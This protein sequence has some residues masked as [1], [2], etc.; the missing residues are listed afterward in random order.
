MTGKEFAEPALYVINL[1]D[2]TERLSKISEQLERLNLDF[3]RVSGVDGRE[4]EQDSLPHYD[5]HTA[6]RYL[7]R[8][9]SLG[10][11]GCF[12][13]HLEC[14]RRFMKSGDNSAL[15]LEDDAVF[16]DSFKE[17][18]N[19][20]MSLY[21]NNN[22]KSLDG[23]WDVISLCAERHKIYTEICQLPNGNTLT[24]AHYFPMRCT[25]LLWSRSG[26]ERFLRDFDVMDC[27]YDIYI[28][29]WVGI[30]NS[31]LAVW[32]GVVRQ[33]GAVSDI[34]AAG[35]DRRAKSGR[36]RLYFLRRLRRTLADKVRA[37]AKTPRQME[38]C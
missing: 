19:S 7:G 20:V 27:P 14:L 6:K 32:P 26:A 13:S 30:T 1:D 17:T 3:T 9:L 34:S 37:P 2:S 24:Q 12:L 16:L 5:D 10:E 28:R 35:A 18:L 25:A 21:L 15:I 38:V 23:N 36:S 33:S 11:I 22:K 4:M 29:R 31:A 8:S